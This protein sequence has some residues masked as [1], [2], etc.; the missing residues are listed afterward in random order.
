MEVPG[1]AAGLG[2]ARIAMR[3]AALTAKLAA[4]SPNAHDAPTAATSSPPRAGP[5]NCSPRCRVDAVRPEPA[6]KR[7]LGRI[8]GTIAVMVGRK[9]ASAVPN[10]TAIT[11]RCQSSSS[12]EAART[13]IA[14]TASPRAMS[15]TMAVR[16]RG[17]RSLTAPAIR[18]NRTRGSALAA[19]TEARAVGRPDRSRAWSA[20]ATVNTPLPTSETDCPAHS[21]AKSRSRRGRR[22]PERPD[23]R[24]R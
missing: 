4:S 15:E 10:T 1:S 7:S 23:T 11:I 21:R 19:R 16:R 20:S 22:I 6:T 13:A 18:R 24:P 14:P 17:S 5:I 2:R 8:S 9:N 12:P 3:H